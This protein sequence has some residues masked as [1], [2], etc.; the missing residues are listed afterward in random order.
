[1]AVRK[2]NEWSQAKEV[3]EIAENTPYRMRSP[4][5]SLSAHAPTANLGIDPPQV[6]SSMLPP[7]SS[8]VCVETRTGVVSLM[9]ER[10]RVGPNASLADV[11]RDAQITLTRAAALRARRA[12][13]AE[14]LAAAKHLVRRRYAWRGYDVVDPDHS[15]AAE[16]PEHRVVFVAVDGDSTVGTVT[17]G[18]DGDRGLL[19]EGTYPEI[20]QE[21]RAAGCN[22]CEV[23]RL[24]VAEEAESKPV[25]ASLFSVA[26]ATA[27]MRGVTDVFVEV[28][29]RH[30]IFYRRV[31]GFALAA[32]EKF[33]ERVKAP[34]VLLWLT[35]DELEKR[36]VR[37]NEAVAP[38]ARVAR[39]A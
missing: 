22:V 3:I 37:L 4:L 26:F 32:G 12:H 17:L 28:N 25:L 19:A 24:A 23:T 21:R 1:M 5:P 38:T 35:M 29:P 27:S 31:L 10:R 34:S 39:A 14:D 6:L 15:I 7:P 36:L 18:L 11:A 9:T 8:T 33:C 13:T 30:V 20:V 2:K 16:L